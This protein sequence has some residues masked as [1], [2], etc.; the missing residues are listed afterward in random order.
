[1]DT[2]KIIYLIRKIKKKN[3]KKHLNLIFFLILY[4]F[5]FFFFSTGNMDKKSILKLI[6]R[7]SFFSKY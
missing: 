4:F 6:K 5:C 3:L 7:S 2:I 1:M